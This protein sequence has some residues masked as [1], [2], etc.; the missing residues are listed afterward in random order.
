M[1]TC[2]LSIEDA[3]QAG[4]LQRIAIHS[5]LDLCHHDPLVLSELA[6]WRGREMVDTLRHIEGLPPGFA[7]DL[8]GIRR[9]LKTCNRK[10]VAMG[11]VHETYDQGKLEEYQELF[12]S[13]DEDGSG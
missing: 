4:T 2:V 6:Y 7:L 11:E 8:E 1:E 13:L 12:S 3:P 9:E 10:S 5:L